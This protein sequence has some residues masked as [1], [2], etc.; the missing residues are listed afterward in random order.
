MVYWTGCIHES[1]IPGYRRRVQSSKLPC[2]YYLFVVLCFFIY[3]VI[4]CMHGCLFLCIIIIHKHGCL[5]SH[6]CVYSWQNSN[7]I[8]LF[9]LYIF[10]FIIIITCIHGCLFFHLCVHR[11]AKN[12]RNGQC[13]LIVFS[14]TRFSE[15]LV[16][17]ESDYPGI[18]D[19][20]CNYNVCMKVWILI[21]FLFRIIAMILEVMRKRK[22]KRKK[23]LFPQREREREREGRERKILSLC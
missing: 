20:I 16:G 13:Q 14:W 23:T 18:G 2:R 9:I 4:I 8:I 12:A 3:F 6:F 5:F 19:F 21:F 10:C 17:I 7:I 22:R 15:T 1:E 11:L